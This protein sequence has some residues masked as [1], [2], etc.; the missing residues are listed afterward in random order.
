MGFGR[1]PAGS[2]ARCEDLKQMIQSEVTGRDFPGG[3]VVSTRRFHG[4]VHGFDPWWDN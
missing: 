4:R 3:P 1:S 2:E